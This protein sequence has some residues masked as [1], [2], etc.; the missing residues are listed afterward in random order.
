VRRSVVGFGA[1][2][3]A[4]TVLDEAVIGDQARLGADLELRGGA[5]VW[6]GAQLA[7][8]TVRFSAG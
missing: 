7:D 6:P 4:R 5:R 2:V 3:G 8:G 1:H